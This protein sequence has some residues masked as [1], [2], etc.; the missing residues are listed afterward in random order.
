MKRKLSSISYAQYM[1]DSLQQLSSKFSIRSYKTAKVEDWVFEKGRDTIIKIF[2]ENTPIYEFII[3]KTFWNQRNIDSKDKEYMRIPDNINLNPQQYSRY[4]GLQT[5][6][7]SPMY[8]RLTPDQLKREYAKALV[9][10][11]GIFDANAWIAREF[12]G[13]MV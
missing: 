7:T 10:E 4:H 13:G 12:G 6:P 1:K 3:E 8:G 11:P 5:L 9:G 2:W